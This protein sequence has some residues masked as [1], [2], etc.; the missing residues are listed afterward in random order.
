MHEIEQPDVSPEK[1]IL[2]LTFYG[3]QL[4][5]IDEV[6][7][8]LFQPGLRPAQGDLPYS[9]IV[10]GMLNH[11]YVRYWDEISSVPYFYRAERKIFVSYEDA[12][13]LARKEH[14]VAISIWPAS[15]F[16]T[17]LEIPQ[18]PSTCDRWRLRIS[19]GVRLYEISG[20]FYVD[21]FD[22][23]VFQEWYC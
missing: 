15:Y 13:S 10:S 8:G 12:E 14:H 6:H 21:S 5:G 2:G 1:I 9:S 23:I 17:I 11:G 19:V 20:I 16:G 7:R 4:A 18:H 3:H 22:S